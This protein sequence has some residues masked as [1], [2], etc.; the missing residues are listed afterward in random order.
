LTVEKGELGEARAMA[1]AVK[2]ADAPPPDA[3]HLLNN[4]G[5][6][7]LMSGEEGQVKKDL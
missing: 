5:N 7:V 4:S 3:T 6:E 1:S 2:G